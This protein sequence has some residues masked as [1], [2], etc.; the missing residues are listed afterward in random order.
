MSVR[1]AILEDAR[2]WA[3]DHAWRRRL[4]ADGRQIECCLPG[5]LSELH[6]VVV[7][8]TLA[9]G[10]NAL[11]LSGSTARRTRTDISD[12]DY[13]LVGPRIE[14]KDLSRQL[15]VHVLSKE[16]LRSEILAGDDFVQWSVR[17][18][19]VVFDDGVVRRTLGLIEDRRLWPSVD[20]KREHARKSLKLAER[21]VATGD[22]DGAL[23]QVRTA[24][25]L[26]ARASLLSSGIFPMSRA[27]LPA[28]LQGIGSGG[29][30]KALSATIHGSPSLSELEEAVAEGREMLAVRVG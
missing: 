13:H 25:S 20:R 30:A 29:V 9:V 22:E 4:E 21:F 5:A 19:R 28:Q 24:L 11:I 26:A 16:K 12:L 6:G 3:D 27:E 7:R 15:D 23:A 17:F 8:R 10:A 18:G 2:S 14:T 1:D